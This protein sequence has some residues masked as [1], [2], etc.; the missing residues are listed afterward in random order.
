MIVPFPAGQATDMVARMLAEG[1]ARLWGQPVV[2]DN[3][4]GVPGMMAGKDAAPD[5]Y[6]LTLGTSGTLAVNPAVMAK[7]A[8]DA[9]QDYAMIHG[10]ATVPMMIVTS[11]SAPFQS[12]KDVIEAAQKEPGKFNVAY[13]G[14]NNTQHLT[15]ELLKAQAKIDVVGVTYKG[16]AAAVTDL[17]GGQVTLL[18]DSLASTL[19]H[20]KAGKMRA[21]AISSSQ[22]VPQMPDLPTV[23]ETF[24]GFEGVGWA[25]LVAPKGTPQAIIDKISDDT[26]KVLNDPKMRDLIIERGLVPDIRGA[27]EWGEF[28]NAE[29]IKWTEVA[30]KVGLKPE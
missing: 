1:L 25:G 28:V 9:K 8:Y 20:I 18:V 30:R 2:V 27:K 14:V 15:G 21:L 7:L 10:G 3:R 29:V 17:L 5:G 11:A 26:L 6:T 16:S 4:P 24:P 12:L 19:P 13:G 23:A 22:R